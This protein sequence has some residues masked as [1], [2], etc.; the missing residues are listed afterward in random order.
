G[1]VL[2]VYSLSRLARSTR[3]TLDIA[4]R[5][6]K[7]G[8]DLVSLSE[9]IDTTSA[10][11]KMIFRMLAVLAE[12]ERDVISE[13]TK[14]ALQHKKANSERVGTVPFGYE[15]APDGASLVENDTEQQTVA[16]INELRDAGLS[17]RAI[18]AELTERRISTKKGNTRWAHTAVARILKRTA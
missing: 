12:F 7:S 4:E 2:I 3:D 9:K 16:L 8:A 10:A 13:R 18:A 5:L 6:E 15:L 1:A 11:G 17:T 14:T